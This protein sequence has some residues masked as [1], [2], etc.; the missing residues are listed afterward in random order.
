L[1]VDAQLGV[2][3]Y[4]QPLNVNRLTAGLAEPERAL[5]EALQ[6]SFDST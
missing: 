2:R 1:T 3:L 5:S 4:E 6:G